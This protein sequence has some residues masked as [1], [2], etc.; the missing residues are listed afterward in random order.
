MLLK[1]YS[2]VRLLWVLPLRFLLDIVLALK[3]LLTLDLKRVVA[4]GAGYLWLTF[5]P[6][7]ICRKRRAV[8]QQRKISDG[9][10]S[11]RLFP[12]SLVFSYYLQRKKTF[13]EIAGKAGG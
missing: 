7:L 10:I 8:Q 5:H 12:V 3:S 4:V 13:A 9:I 11:S 1:N 6:L 2:A